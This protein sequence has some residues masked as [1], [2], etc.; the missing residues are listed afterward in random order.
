MDKKKKIIALLLVAVMV[1]FTGC[2]GS[3]DN[4]GGKI[5]IT[6]NHGYST[7]DDT[8]PCQ[9]FAKKFIEY[10]EAE[11]GD[12]VS[13]NIVGDSLGGDDLELLDGIRAGSGSILITTPDDM[14]TY[15]PTLTMPGMPFIFNTVEEAEAY[16]DSEI[17]QAELDKYAE[18]FNGHVLGLGINGFRVMIG[19][20]QAIHSISDFAGQKWRVPQDD[21]SVKIY[22]ALGANPVPV[23]G[24]EMFSALQQGVVD[25]QCLPV[26][27]V[28][29]YG[30][31][32]I[33]TY[34]DV[35]NHIFTSWAMVM[36]N[37]LYESLSPEL[38]QIFD[39]AGRKAALEQRALV[40]SE[41]DTQLQEIADAGVAVNTDVDTEPMREAMDS[42]YKE[43]REILGADFWD[44]SMEFIAQLRAE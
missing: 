15:Q 30:Y 38:Q 44:T 7:A 37:E 31:Q 33:I 19:N 2:G 27:G 43:Y 39:E 28:V 21:L 29:S 20:K 32:D 34:L 16:L 26:E 40:E 8:N 3:T 41:Y 4:E 11:A 6:I 9:Y 14:G 10:V 12:Q 22:K 42:V 1:F 5:E 13:F 23:S 18:D 25:G 17:F 24:S 35:T 36:D